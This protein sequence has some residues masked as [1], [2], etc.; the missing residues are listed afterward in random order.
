MLDEPFVSVPNG[1]LRFEHLTRDL[2]VE[3][4]ARQQVATKLPAA[5][6]RYVVLFSPRSGSSWLT[7][8]LSSTQRLG[9]P[10]EYINPDFIVDVARFVNA[11]NP[12]H[13]LDALVRRRK[14]PNGVFGM[15]TRAIDVELLGFDAFRD[16]FVH[17]TLFFHLWRENLVAQAVSLYR[18]VKTE[19]F[20][21]N[22]EKAAM[23]PEYDPDRICWWMEHILETENSNVRLLRHLNVPAR[24]LRYEDVIGDRSRAAELFAHAL[25][26]PFSAGEFAGHQDQDLIK[27]ADDWN[28]ATEARVRWDR[29]DLIEG[30][31]QSRLI[32]AGIGADPHPAPPSAAARRAVWD[33]GWRSGTAGRSPRNNPFPVDSAEHRDWHAG[34]LVGWDDERYAG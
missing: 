7:E 2:A 28:A 20:H 27:I 32:T 26:V 6:R 1:L 14:T 8:V 16:F 4:W 10:E 12:L 19:H 31:E 9:F 5:Q 15:E 18:A 22:D 11:K 3:E 33:K 17:D 29:R 21:S 23:T 25:A 34:W 13:L 24:H 30:L